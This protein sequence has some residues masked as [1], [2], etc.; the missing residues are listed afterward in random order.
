[1]TQTPPFADQI[2][3][4]EDRSAA[5]RSAV[6]GADLTAA[7]P[8]CPGWTVRDLAT[9][10]G[11]VHRFWAVAVAA[12]PAAERPSDAALG[13]REPSGDLL[14]W[15]AE[16]TRRLVGALRTAGPGAGCWTWWEASGAPMTAGAVARHQVQEA[17]VHAWDAQSAAG[18]PEPIPAAA[19]VD[20]IPEFLEVGLGSLGPWPHR[21]ARLA[22]SATDGPAWTVD[23]TP[24]GAEAHPAAAGEPVVTVRAAASDLLLFLFNRIPAEA[25]TVTGDA[26]VLGELRSWTSGD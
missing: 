2:G 18:E 5:F 6:T 20:A 17:A 11:N 3:L 15:S 7:V 1:M 21:P 8:G 10:L 19:A 25:V 12:G 9:H 23:L 13:S 22:L 24:A 26:S 16:S 4:I 14:E